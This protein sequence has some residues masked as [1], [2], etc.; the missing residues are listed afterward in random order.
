MHI[1][2]ADSSVIAAVVYLEADQALAVEFTSGARYRYLGVP[3][4]VVHDFLSAASKGLFFN[5]TI[6]PCYPCTKL[7]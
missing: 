5:R 2:I 1:R 7:T 4:E 6:R 3:A